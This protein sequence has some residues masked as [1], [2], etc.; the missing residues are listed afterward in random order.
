MVN[1]GVPLPVIQKLLDHDSITMT[2]R[3]AQLHEET[4]RREI[5]RWHERVNGRGDLALGL[6]PSSS[7]LDFSPSGARIIHASIVCPALLLRSYSL[8]SSIYLR[9]TPKSTV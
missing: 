2:A 4:L 3:Y 1:D 5:S 8:P 9:R 6:Q 7:R